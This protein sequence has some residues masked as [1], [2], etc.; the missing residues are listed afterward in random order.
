MEQ[1]LIVMLVCSNLPVDPRVEREAR[2]LVARG[3][4]VKILCPQWTPITPPPDWGAGIE[5][6]V[7]QPERILHPLHYFPYVHAPALVRAAL[8]EPA[9]AYHSHDLNTALAALLAAARKSAGAST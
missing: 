9:W 8:A 2:A 1:P 3:F 4:R 5:V 6:R 7:L